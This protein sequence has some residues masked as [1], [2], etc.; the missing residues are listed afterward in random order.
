MPEGGE[1]TITTANVVLSE[2]Q[3]RGRAEVPPGAYVRL[4]VC[5]TGRGI[6]AELR[7]KVFEPFFTTKRPGE[8]TGLGLSTVY[9][10]VKQS[11]GFIFADSR[12]G[13]GAEFSIFL[14]A[15]SMPAAPAPRTEAPGSIPGHGEGIVLLAEDEAPVRA[16]AARALRLRG[17]TVIEAE[18]GEHA[19]DLLADP[20]LHVDV[21]VTDVIMPGRD[22]PGWVREALKTRPAVRVIFVSGYAEDALD[23]GAARI[24]GAVFLPKP[25]SLGE[26]AGAV[27]AQ[28][29]AAPSAGD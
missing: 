22:G 5:D 12:P 23:D 7:D 10:I 14:P 11:G 13:T 15:R 27:Q 19:L 2:P 25:F 17:Y 1:I 4:S 29:A 24:P 20:G 26:L 28:I 16:F 18:T 8:G 6:P 3:R 21:F 9:G